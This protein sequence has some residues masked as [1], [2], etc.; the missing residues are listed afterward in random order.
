LVDGE[1]LGARPGVAY[2]HPNPTVGPVSASAV[3]FDLLV[4]DTYFEGDAAAV[5]TAFMACGGDRRVVSFDSSATEL[6]L[7]GLRA[8]L[9]SATTAL[10]FCHVSGAMWVANSVGLVVGP[11]RT[12][13]V[14][15]IAEL[16]LRNLSELAIVGC[17]SGRSNPFVGEITV[18]HAAALAGAGEVLHTLWPI[19][20]DF[21]AALVADMLSARAKG[22]PT[23]DFVARLYRDDRNRAAALAMLRP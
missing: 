21:A 7:A 5:E 8:A 14:E 12:L 15:E 1:P 2:V 10:L 17:G 4:V 20:S 19:S 3:P 16:D 9:E 13:T 22:I 6:D 23:R 18:A 11:D